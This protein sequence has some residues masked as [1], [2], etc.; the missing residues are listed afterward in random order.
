[1]NVA[2]LPFDGACQRLALASV[3]ARIGQTSVLS[4][5]SKASQPLL[6]KLW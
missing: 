2:V 3:L 4:A 5:N 6:A 1:M